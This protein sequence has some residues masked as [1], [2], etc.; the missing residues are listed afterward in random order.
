MTEAAAGTAATRSGTRLT[1]QQRKAI[2]AGSI[3]NTVEW[4]CSA[5]P[6][7]QFAE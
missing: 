2:V 7:A 4:D 1:G 6:T 5:I 3:G